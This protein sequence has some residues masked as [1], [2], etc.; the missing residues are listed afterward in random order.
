MVCQHRRHIE[1]AASRVDHRPEVPSGSPRPEEASAAHLSQ[2][3]RS[4]CALA[5]FPRSERGCRQ[6]SRNCCP[7]VSATRGR[8]KKASHTTHPSKHLY[9]IHNLSCFTPLFLLS[10][11]QK[12]PRGLQGSLHPN[13][14]FICKSSFAQLWQIRS[15]LT[16]DDTALIHRP[17]QT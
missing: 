17:L 16:P 6:R 1:P 7:L 8:S 9:D 14:L 2:G 5:L 11:A 10:A 4:R 3:A 12:I 15:F 13:F